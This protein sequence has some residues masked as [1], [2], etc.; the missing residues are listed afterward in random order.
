[1]K[2][3]FEDRDIEAPPGASVLET[4]ELAGI[5]I[6]SSCRAGACQ[7]CLLQ[8][9]EGQP[10]TAAQ[11]GLPRNL[12]AEG[13]FLSCVCVPTEPLTIV[14]A[15]SARQRV[16]A[17]LKERRWLS[18]NVLGLTLATDSPFTCHPGQFLTLVLPDSGLARSYSIAGCRAGLVELHVRILPDGRMSQQLAGDVPDGTPFILSGPAG[19]CFYDGVDSERRLI[20]AGTGTGLA[21]LWAILHDALDRGHRGPIHLYH[22]A[23][24][25]SGFYLV[26]ELRSL[27]SR[28][29]SFHYQPTTENLVAVVKSSETTPADSEFF[30]CGDAGLVNTLRRALFLR[31]AKLDRL[32]ADA[33]VAAASGRS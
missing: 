26:D 29:P 5:A 3:R 1:M 14:R 6:E 2:L 18:S 16:G 9:T 31:G 4:L 27:A 25:E 19:N 23:R 8:C 10:P 22:G 33:F 15:G 21:P 17:T 11:A 12:V 28:H 30:L 13:C 32:H 20:L 7:S 24:D